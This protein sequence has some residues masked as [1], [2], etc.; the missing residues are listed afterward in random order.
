MSDQATNGAAAP[1]E[2]HAIFE[3]EGHV[4]TL[5]LNR[6][7]KR[8]ALSSEM[9]VRMY[10]AW[11]EVDSNP[12]IR[13]L[14]VTGA[15]GNFCSGA[16]LKAMA[17]GLRRRPHRVV[18]ADLGRRGPALE[19][20]AAPLHPRQAHHRRRGGLRGG[21]GHRDPAGHGHPRGG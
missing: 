4:A 8:N 12:D 19:G 7:A 15:G 21:R 6:P 1:E 10:D 13:V 17:V 14:I 3:H 2:P 16:D 9:L 18:R 20:A 5:T 11:V